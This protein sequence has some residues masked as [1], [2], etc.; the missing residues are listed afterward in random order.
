MTIACQNVDV[1]AVGSISFTST[2]SGAAIYIDNV[3]QIGTTPGTI[4]D[5]A[6]GSHS[7]KL[8]LSGYEDYTD[9]AVTVTD[10]GTTS[11][12]ITF[13]GSVYMTSTP[14][15]AEI[16]L[17]PSPDAP[18]DQLATTPQTFAGMTAASSG[19]TTTW[20]YKLT[21]AGHSDKTGSFLATAGTTTTAPLVTWTPASITATGMVVTPSASP[22]IEGLCTIH[23]DVTWANNGETD[24]IFTPNIT[25]DTIPVSPEPYPSQALAAGAT[26]TKGFDITDKLANTYVICPSPN[27]P[28]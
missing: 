21:L 26:V 14:S 25:I 16:F 19:A 2:P 22:C 23:V 8:T 28:A 11:I 9:P 5:I 6:V 15:G 4:S 1:V 17:A 18:I 12:T 20:N 7:I 13:A 10:G 27:A 24:G 3:L